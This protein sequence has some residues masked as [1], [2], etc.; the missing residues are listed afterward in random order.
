MKLK[1]IETFLSSNINIYDPVNYQSDNRLPENWRCRVVFRRHLVTLEADARSCSQ[2]EVGRVVAIK[3]DEVRNIVGLQR[4]IDSSNFRC[5]VVFR[6]IFIEFVDAKF[7]ACHVG[8]VLAVVRHVEVLDDFV[9]ASFQLQ[10]LDMETTKVFIK[11]KL[12]EST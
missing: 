6:R 4:Q 11:K 3:V 10:N 9:V 2:E 8:D 5:F 7:R 12:Y 1:K